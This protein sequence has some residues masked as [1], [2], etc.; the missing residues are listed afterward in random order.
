MSDVHQM[1]LKSLDEYGQKV[2]ALFALCVDKLPP[3]G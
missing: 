3:E 1:V 2:L